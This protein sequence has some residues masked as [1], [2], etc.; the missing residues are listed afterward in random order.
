MFN[1]VREEWEKVGDV[2]GDQFKAVHDHVGLDSQED[3][4]LGLSDGECGEYVHERTRDDVVVCWVARC[5]SQIL[6]LGIQMGWG[7]L[8]EQLVTL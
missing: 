1:E 3:V 5:I 6:S 8:I 7:R 2:P 4:L